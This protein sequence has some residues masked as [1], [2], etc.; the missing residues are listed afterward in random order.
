MRCDFKCVKLGFMR[1]HHLSGLICAMQASAFNAHMICIEFLLFCPLDKMFRILILNV[2]QCQSYSTAPIIWKNEI[3]NHYLHAHKMVLLPIN[4][5]KLLIYMTFLKF[6]VRWTYHATR[7]LIRLNE[8]NK[9]HFFV[10]LMVEI[11]YF[12]SNVHQ[13]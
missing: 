3:F 1:T 2:I 7:T 12:A 9:N 8:F 10:S 5:I 6:I 4:G 13:I 11:W